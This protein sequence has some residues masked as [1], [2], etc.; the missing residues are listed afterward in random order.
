MHFCR[1]VGFWPA[2]IL[3]LCSEQIQGP[4]RC[5]L[6]SPIG[7]SNMPQHAYCIFLSIHVE[8]KF[9]TNNNN[10]L[11]GSP[12]QM[13]GTPPLLLLELPP[14]V[15]APHPIP[16]PKATFWRNLILATQLLSQINSQPSPSH[17]S[18][19]EIPRNVQKALLELTVEDLMDGVL[20]KCSQCICASC[21]GF[22][23]SVW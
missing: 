18:V 13:P 14:N 19:P 6:L 16:N 1:F 9:C 2:F 3:M 23:S 8:G 21:L 11:G 10:K 5:K 17:L 12:G 4:M 22:T 7:K 20:T 15:W